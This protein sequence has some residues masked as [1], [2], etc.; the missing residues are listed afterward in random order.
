M[1]APLELSDLLSPF[2]RPLSSERVLVDDPLNHLCDQV[3]GRL[4]GCDQAGAQHDGPVSDACVLRDGRPASYCRQDRQA[5]GVRAWS[6]GTRL[7][8]PGASA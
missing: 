5:G 6:A 3:A 4:N 7:R 2:L 8:C 1:S